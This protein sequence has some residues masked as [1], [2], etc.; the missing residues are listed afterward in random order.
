M[1]ADVDALPSTCW[2]YI[3]DIFAIWS[4]GEE[5]LTEFLE[6]INQ[7]HPSIKFTTEW[8]PKSDAFLDTTVSVDNE[9]C[10]TTD[11]YV[12]R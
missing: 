5:Q 1:L 4:H 3:Y 8:V 7:F 9:G 6:K 10:L 12:N 11:L 2:R